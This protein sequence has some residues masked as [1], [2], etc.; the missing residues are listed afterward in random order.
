LI[1]ETLVCHYGDI[2]IFWDVVFVLTP[3]NFSFDQH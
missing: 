1:K 2:R 3:Y